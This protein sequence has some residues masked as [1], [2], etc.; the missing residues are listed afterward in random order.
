MDKDYI[1]FGAG[2]QSK[3]IGKDNSISEYMTT[4]FAL[5]ALMGQVCVVVF[6]VAFLVLYFVGLM[7]QWAAILAAI[8]AAIPPF[9]VGNLAFVYL[10]KV[11]AINE[12]M[13]TR[14][15]NGRF[16]KTRVNSMGKH[17]ADIVTAE[18]G[19]SE[20]VTRWGGGG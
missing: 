14:D 6:V 13:P 9:A 1:E 16:R 3:V 8:L 5:L 7:W 12:P 17:V 11:K 2:N 4:I 10:A 19:E 15:K 18:N 20:W